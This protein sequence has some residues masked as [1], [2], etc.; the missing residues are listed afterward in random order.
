MFPTG[1]YECGFTSGS[2]MHTARTQLSVVLL[3]DEINLEINPLTVDCSLNPPTIDV[4]VTVTILN[5][6]E[7]FD[8]W[9]SYRGVR[10]SDLFNQC[11]ANLQELSN[12]SAPFPISCKLRHKRLLYNINAN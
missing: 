8:A 1:E 11:K 5:S 10:M 6:T 4:A 7:N 2:V 12:L 3:P 9:W